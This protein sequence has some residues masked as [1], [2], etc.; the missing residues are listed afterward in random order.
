MAALGLEGDDPVDVE[1]VLANA[2]R[3]IDASD[4]QSNPSAS[5]ATTRSS[6][7]PHLREKVSQ[8]SQPTSST[9]PVSSRITSDAGA[10]AY[11]LL[12]PHLRPRAP[13]SSIST[14]TT[15]RNDRKEKVKNRE[16]G[17]IAY[18][19]DGI[20]HQ[21]TRV[22]TTVDSSATSEVSQDTASRTPS[23]AGPLPDRQ[24]RL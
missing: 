20:Q 18:A 23:Q 9:P 8:P 4:A 16:I 3:P 6:L 15:I 17:F 5:Q 24:A 10:A 1:K 2:S 21:R 19:P 14:A 11:S 12:P 22:P 13:P 7:P